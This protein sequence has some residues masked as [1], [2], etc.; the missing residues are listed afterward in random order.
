[1][2]YS[3]ENNP[4]IPGDPY[5]Y[6]LK[7]IV[8]EIKTIKDP[9]K[10]AAEAKASAEAA[11]VSEENA[12]Q[13]ALNAAAVV[14]NLNAFY[15]LIIMPEKY[16]AVGDG[17]TDDTT[18]FNDMFTAVRAM[19]NSNGTMFQM[20]SGA[21]ILL[22]GKYLIT[23]P[24]SIDGLHGV[25]I[26]GSTATS[27]EILSANN[28]IFTST[29]DSYGLRDFSIEN[30]GFIY[31]GVSNSDYLL[32][33]TRPRDVK[34]KDCIF[35][36]NA[37][38]DLSLAHGIGIIL[39][40]T[41]GIE[42]SNTIFYELYYGVQFVANVSLGQMT[43]INLLNCWFAL[44]NFGITAALS[45]TTAYLSNLNIM[46]SIFDGCT[47]GVN[48]VSN[49]TYPSKAIFKNCYFESNS[50]ASILASSSIIDFDETNFIY[51]GSGSVGIIAY[52][53]SIS[54]NLNGNAYGKIKLM[55]ANAINDISGV[56]PNNTNINVDIECPEWSY[57]TTNKKIRIANKQAIRTNMYTGTATIYKITFSNG[58]DFWIGTGELSGGVFTATRL[59]GNI[60]MI[61]DNL[62]SMQAPS[63]GDWIIEY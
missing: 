28:S 32:S 8:N 15:N 55:T 29:D 45:G 35:R 40:T 14:D 6:D 43:T 24:V 50:F 36:S 44:C 31:T 37:A 11:A 51:I 20:E 4:Y 5:S 2:G 56:A 9:E 27:T 10:S 48:L 42:I 23:S 58:S 53:S 19:C 25:K 13:S 52:Y 61:S 38:Y 62:T 7:W 47:R 39:S 30:V 41:V 59:A 3:P 26:K 17:V 49:A 57:N 34:I 33:I 16:G 1:M 18:A 63:V 54:N 21:T 60:T 46:N 12:A 22:T